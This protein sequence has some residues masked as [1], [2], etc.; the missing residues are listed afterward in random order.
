MAR[1]K[2][3]TDMGDMD[4][5]EALGTARQDL[6]NLRFQ[7]ATG[8]LDD[9]SSL[10]KARRNVARLMTELRVRDI[11]ATEDAIA[12]AVAAGAAADNADDAADGFD[13]ANADDNDD[14]AD[15]FDAASIEADDDDDADRD[16]V[17]DDDKNDDN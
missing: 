14:A 16:D 12:E 2:S 4:L 8:Q 7:F 9:S 3:V 11:E 10:S 17:D 5:L 13:A 15:D 6:F 1:A